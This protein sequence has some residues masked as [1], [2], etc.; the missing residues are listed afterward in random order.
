MGTAFA[1]CAA[2]AEFAAAD[3]PAG[4]VGRVCSSLPEHPLRAWAA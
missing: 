3:W 4:W 2:A 1:G